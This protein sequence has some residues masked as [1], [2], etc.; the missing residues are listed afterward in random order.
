MRRSISFAIMTI[1][2]MLA[3][4]ARADG[5]TPM[6]LQGLL[7]AGPKPDATQTA[8]AAY[9]LARGAVQSAGGD[10][11][12]A[13]VLSSAAG[14]LNH[15]ALADRAGE[16]PAIAD[17]AAQGSPVG[18]AAIATIL[19]PQAGG[20]VRLTLAPMTQL[21]AGAFVTSPL[22][23]SGTTITAVGPAMSVTVS[24]T[25]DVATLIDAEQQSAAR[26]SGMSNQLHFAA[27]F[28]VP[29]G[30]AVTG[31][32]VP[33]GAVVAGLAYPQAG[34][35]MVYLT[36][37]VSADV[38]AGAAIGFSSVSETV[39][40]SAAWLAAAPAGTT[41][42][43]ASQDDW[44]TFQNAA[45]WSARANGGKGGRIFVPSGSYFLSAPVTTYDGVSFELAPQVSFVPG[46]SVID[47]ADAGFAST[48]ELSVFGGYRNPTATTVNISQAVYQDIMPSLQGQALLVNQ[49]NVNCTNDG[50]IAGCGIVAQEVKQ[51]V[52]ANVRRGTLWGYHETDSISAGQS[53]SWA[54]AEIELQ[55]NSAADVVWNSLEGSKT[56]LHIDNIGNT[57]NSV[58]LLP[59]GT[60]GSGGGGWHRG[61]DCPAMAISDY[62]FDIQTGPLQA[63]TYAPV[64]L[65][66][67]DMTGKYTGTALSITGNAVI[68]G[69]LRASAS[70][71]SSPAAASY[72]VQT[73]DCGTTIEPAAT[74]ATVVT[75]PSGLP[76][77]CRIDVNQVGP[78]QISFQAGSSMTMHAYNGATKLAG[79]YASARI[80]V[81]SANAFL[82]SGQIQ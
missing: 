30:A 57:M 24:Q 79:T 58:V 77:G 44:S 7:A 64:I 20:D 75:V 16:R 9:S 17:Y 65:A 5:P 73:S 61:L 71:V 40:L 2:A 33:A 23:P 3:A 32:T 43:L 11:G 80:L 26:M 27:V 14:T 29:Q 82:L 46:S 4:Q 13:L 63:G 45:F 6:Q 76:L 10:A 68:G 53:I 78:A 66:G 42:G 38:P 48:A 19:Q 28:A 50:S 15:R 74:S 47:T 56:G 62:C 8:A 52:A 54:G 69:S 60:I 39:T 59:G 81:D 37:N 25:T 36:A 21:R 49:L 34:G 41:V 1:A 70:V 72:L 31:S 22:L 12:Q 35:T 18:G 51:A 67:L 55:N